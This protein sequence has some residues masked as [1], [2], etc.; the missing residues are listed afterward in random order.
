[1]AQVW[2]FLLT[3]VPDRVNYLQL[4]TFMADPVSYEWL[5]AER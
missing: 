3:Y 2:L 1:M 4:S 5:V